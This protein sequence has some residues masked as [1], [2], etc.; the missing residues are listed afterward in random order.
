MENLQ[1]EVTVVLSVE[2]LA[3]S[4]FTHR[5]VYPEVLVSINYDASH[6]DGLSLFTPNGNVARFLTLGFFLAMK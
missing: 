6:L 3:F 1:W 2:D 5:P 4:G